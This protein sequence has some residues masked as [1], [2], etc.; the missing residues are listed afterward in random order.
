MARVIDGDSDEKCAKRRVAPVTRYG[1]RQRH[2]H[3]VHQVFASAR[4]AHQASRE[5]ADGC[6]M[7]VVHLADRIRIPA[8]EARDERLDVVRRVGER[9]TR[10]GQ[11]LDHGVTLRFPRDTKPFTRADSAIVSVDY[12]GVPR[13]R[14]GS[15]RSRSPARRSLRTA[16]GRG[17]H[18]SQRTPRAARRCGVRRRPGSAESPLRRLVIARREP[19]VSDVAA[20]LERDPVERRGR[21]ETPAARSEDRRPLPRACAARCSRRSSCPR[22]AANRSSRRRTSRPR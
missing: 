7:P 5:R 21:S 17:L 4:I 2:E 8:L 9:R 11:K 13:A 12:E 16:K 10:E 19:G 15:T 1:F 20:E 3:V 18:R 22:R 6:V 14:T